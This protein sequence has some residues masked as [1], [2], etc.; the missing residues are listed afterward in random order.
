MMAEDDDRFDYEPTPPEWM[1]DAATTNVVPLR[2]KPLPPGPTA[3]EP[4]QGLKH[5]PSVALIGRERMLELAQKKVM[6]LWQDIAV[7]GTVVLVA[8]PPSEGKTTLV[9]L[10]L[11]ARLGTTPVKLLERVILPAPQG[12]FV[13]LIEGEHSEASTMRKMVKSLKVM[14]VD[15]TGL[16]RL[17][18]VARKAVI[19]GSPAWLDIELLIAAGLVSDIGIDTLARV[20]P[21]E[22]NDEAAQVAIFNRLAAAIEKGPTEEDRPTVWAIAHTRK[23]RADAE[24]SSGGLAE[25]SGS[26]QRVG[27]ADTVL[28]VKGEKVDG[29]TVSSCVSFEKLREDPEDYPKPV[30]FSIV[31]GV[32]GE[33]MMANATGAANTRPE[34]PLEERVLEQCRLQPRT[35]GELKRF[36]NRSDRDIDTCISNLFDARAISKTMVTKGGREWP[37]FEA[38]RAREH[39]TRAWDWLEHGTS[40]GPAWDELE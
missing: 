31:K 22:A 14:G 36:F 10:I 8:G 37:A 39:G 23:G 19:V 34:A 15:D 25:V 2:G 29:Q 18:V 33:P 40:M 35:K 11:A 21:A 24:K 27:Q 16:S 6:Y 32:D 30:K 26:V 3:K 28:L 7:A 4:L 1:N 38:R 17:I 9:F 12:R 13:V 5:L 20:A